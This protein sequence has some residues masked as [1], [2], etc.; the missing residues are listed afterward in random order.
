MD[1]NN[2]ILL[3]S[4]IK[5]VFGIDN[6]NMDTEIN[7]LN[8]VS[9][10]NDYFINLLKAKFNI[11]MSTFNYYEYFEE[12]EFILFSIFRKIFPNKKK[13]KVLTVSH[14]LLVINEGKWFEP[15]K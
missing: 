12:D 4:L 14:L 1:D 3:K 9:E 15:E 2:F 6:I 10:D 8:S 11:D 13:K 5:E 7:M